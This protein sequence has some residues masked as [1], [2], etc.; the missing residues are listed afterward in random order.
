MNITDWQDKSEF[1]S[2]VKTPGRHL[3]VFA[4]KW[5]GFCSRFIDQAKSLQNTSAVNILLVD[6]D[7]PDESLWD[8]YSI[9]IVPTVLVFEGGKTV[10]RRD[11]KSFAGLKMSDL[12]DAV[13]ATISAS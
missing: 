4:A 10:F 1:E 11:G 2:R 12:E 5:C 3:V 8:E 6:V 7:E 9:K 13:S